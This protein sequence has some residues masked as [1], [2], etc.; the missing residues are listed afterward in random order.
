M[1]G[2]ESLETEDARR[3]R[4]GYLLVALVFFLVTTP[5]AMHTDLGQF[6]FR[7]L[8]TLVLL[9]GVATMRSREKMF[10]AGLLALPAIAGNWIAT[11]TDTQ[12]AQ[13]FSYAA[14]AIFLA[15]I[16]VT[17]MAGLL[18]ET[19]VTSDT[20]LGGVCV[21]FLAGLIWLMLYALVLEVQPDAI[22]VNGDSMEWSRGDGR[23]TLLYFSYVTLTTLGYGDVV[24]NSTVARM[25][26]SGEAVTGQLF[27]AILIARL[28]GMHI[29]ESQRNEKT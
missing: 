12:S 29:A 28:V 22:L 15:Y 3:S 23:A 4:F 25:L 7:S 17:I 26:A 19:R 2:S 14:S 27:V 13:I 18:G 24:P 1:S 21:Y 5:F 10:I 16:T 11:V 9:G 8:F 6:R 20:V